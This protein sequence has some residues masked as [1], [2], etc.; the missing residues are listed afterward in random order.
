MYNLLYGDLPWVPLL[1]VL[2]AD[3]VTAG[4]LSPPPGGG[5]KIL[6]LDQV[7]NERTNGPQRSVSSAVD[8][9]N[10]ILFWRILYISLV[11]LGPQRKGWCLKVDWASPVCQA[12]THLSASHWVS[13]S[14]QQ[15]VYKL[16]GMQDQTKH[17]SAQA[18]FVLAPITSEKAEKSSLHSQ[19]YLA[20]DRFDLWSQMCSYSV[21]L[22]LI[23]TES[24]WD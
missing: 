24:R 13:H 23:L 4:W 5:L 3:Q 1:S 19:V 9:R 18:E 10:N 17:N 16:I 11:P 6:S 7:Y 12:L 14:L 21:Y 22:R 8:P 15:T 20:H 2:K